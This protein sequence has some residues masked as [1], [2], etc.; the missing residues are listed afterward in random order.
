MTK[1]IFRGILLGA[2][3]AF[4]VCLALIIY[5]QFTTAR[6]SLSQRLRAEAAYLVHGVEKEG[7][8]F[9]ENLPMTDVRVTYVDTD[10]T[11]LF[12]SAA[13]R[14]QLDSHL[15]RQ[16]IRA[17]LETGEG[18]SERY[19][20]TAGK[21]M[22]YYARRTADGRVVRLSLH[23]PSATSLALSIL[24]PAI[25]AALFLVVFSVLLARL[26]S[27]RI[28]SPINEID[29]E[30]PAADNRY[31]EIAPL[32]R[33]ISRQNELIEKQMAD[34]RRHQ[35]EFRA[36]TENME[37][38]FI[39][40]DKK[41]D[42]LSYNRGALRLLGKNQAGG[43]TSVFA[44]NRSAPFRAAVGE[45]LQ[46]RH[47]E[48]TLETDGRVYQLI[49]NPVTANGQQDGAV[50]VILDVTE[51][52]Q[53]EEMRREFTSNVS[54]EMKTPLTSIYGIS[55]MMAS[56]MVRPEDVPDFAR[57]I[58]AE[59]GRLISLINDTIKLSQLDEESIPYERE[60]VDL[61]EEAQQLCRRLAPVAEGQDVTLT[62]S[63]ESVTVHGI[64]TILS[65]IVSNLCDNAIK[66][67]RPG[68][69][70]S[71]SVVPETGEDGI[72]HAVL[73]VADT[74]I[75]IPPEHLDRVFE[76]FYRVDKSHSRAIGGTGLGLSIVKHGAAYHG[77]QVS[78][79]SR[80]GEGTTV[81]IRF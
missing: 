56:G 28:V 45:A 20:D 57:N 53:R 10:G 30:R 41:T 58:H 80:V 37:E 36:I 9:F 77:A 14:V 66:Y 42:I 65:E 55:E 73:T 26:I 13:D 68:G 69:T 75:G 29:P 44:L 23:R 3:T 50:I 27:G 22:R 72:P 1:R 24:T 8:A 4:L 52:R 51:K 48:K 35:D 39:L 76:R 12:D 71:V 7:A 43:G 67:N 31:P 17:A 61:Y 78:L 5:V 40:I 62:L 70:V 16:E 59:S 25:G 33:K 2:F 49:A 64:R 21:I 38:G 54:H 74:G 6:D 63:G 46:G 19:S 60:D 79:R 34:L 15:D 81:Q 11:V 32:I 18:E 47:N